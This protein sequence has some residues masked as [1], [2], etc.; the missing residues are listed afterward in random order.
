MVKSFNR[1]TKIPKAEISP[2]ILAQAGL[3]DWSIKI[4]QAGIE[5]RTFNGASN[6][7]ANIL[8]WKIL[9]DPIPEI[10]SFELLL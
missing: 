4:N 2:S 10:V 8:D 6:Y 9:E 5:L 1:T 3:K 7:P